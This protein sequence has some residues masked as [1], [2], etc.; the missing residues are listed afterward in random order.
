MIGY[1][2]GKVGVLTDGDL[3]YAPSGRCLFSS[4]WGWSND[5]QTIRLVVIVGAGS[6][7]IFPWYKSSVGCWLQPSYLLWIYDYDLE[8]TLLF[9]ISKS[10]GRSLVLLD[11]EPV[12]APDKVFQPISEWRTTTRSHDLWIGTFDDMKEEIRYGVG[13]WFFGGT[14]TIFL[15]DWKIRFKKWMREKCQCI[16]HFNNS[17]VFELLPQHL[18]YEMLQ[19]YKQ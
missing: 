15:Q 8:P 7:F 6:F 4:W 17:Y 1:C 9:A 16:I 18:E 5:Q 12:V 2:G 14:R 3:V 19:T 13:D 10:I 11:V